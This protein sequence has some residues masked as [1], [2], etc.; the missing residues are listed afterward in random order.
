MIFAE[1]LPLADAVA[2]L[3][4]KGVMP[5]NLSSADLRAIDGRIR[6]ESVLS[7][8][9]PHAGYLQD[10]KDQL[11]ELLNGD[12]NMAT[13]RAKLQDMLDALDY[14]PERGFPD[15][16]DGTIPPAERG[17]LQ[18]LS[19]DRRLNLLLET[20]TRQEANRGMQIA[21]QGDFELYAYPAY[22]L[23][24]IYVR[25]VPRG[26]KLVKGE[27]V[28]DPGNDWPARWQEAGGEFFDGR[29]IA[30]KDSPVWPALGDS[31]LFPDALDSDVPPFAFGSGYG[32]RAVPREECVDLGII[33]EDTEIAGAKSER[34]EAAEVAA[35]RPRSLPRAQGRSRRGGERRPVRGSTAAAASWRRLQRSHRQLWRCRTMSGLSSR[36]PSRTRTPSSRGS[37]RSSPACVPRAAPAC[38]VLWRGRR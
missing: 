8:R 34:D 20:K 22:E 29:M 17:S 7:A 27:V 26:E 9:T 11:G 6:E 15:A 14:Q 25:R 28:E 32:W 10:V 2:T 12:T 38:T 24:R 35:E 21:G 23:V 16:G 30:R 37:A 33:D 3:R 13:A 31:A 19:S 4:K 5:T 1:P 18:D 36:S